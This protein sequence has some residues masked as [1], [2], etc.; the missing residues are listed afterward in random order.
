M[1][2]LKTASNKEVHWTLPWNVESE[3]NTRLEQLLGPLSASFATNVVSHG[4]YGWETPD[5]DWKPLTD[6]SSVEEA[7]ARQAFSDLSRRVKGHVAAVF[8]AKAAQYDALVEKILSVPNDGYVFYRVSGGKVEILLTGWGFK[9]YLKPKVAPHATAPSSDMLVRI[10]FT[11]D[12]EL[13]PDCPFAII[14]NTINEVKTGSDGFFVLG[15]LRPGTSL[16]VVNRLNDEEFSLNVQEDK[17]DYVFG[18]TF[19]KPAPDPAPV[20]DPLPEPDPEPDPEPEPEP[21]PDP[22]PDPTPEP[23]PASAPDPEPDMESGQDEDPEPLSDSEPGD[24][25]I[26]LVDK[27]EDAVIGA[28]MTLKGRNGKVFTATTDSRGQIRVPREFF[29]DGKKVKVTI[30]KP[31]HDIRGCKFRY[32]A[33]QDY[34]IIR[35]TDR[36]R[37]RWPW[38]LLL[39]LLPFLLLIKCEH[40]LT[41]TC[42]DEKTKAPVQGVEVTMDYTAHFLLDSAKFFVSTPYSFRDTTDADGKVVFENLRCSVWSYLFYC[43]SK[44]YV[45]ADEVN[46]VERNFHFTRH[47]LMQLENIVCE[48]DIVMCIDNTGS[49]SEFLQMVKS[50]A[51]NFGDDLKKYCA[52][53]RRD[54]AS[55]RVKVVVF[56]DLREC[57]ISQSPMF[58]L[59]EQSEE[60]KKF[61]DNIVCAGGGDDP[62]NGL[63]ALALAMN[64]D[65]RR[66]AHRHRHIIVMYTDASAHPL[67]DP[68]THTVYYPDDMPS[69]FRELTRRWRRMEKGVKRLVLYAPALYPWTEISSSWPEAT[70]C[71]DN[72]ESVF[73]G[74]SYERILEEICRSL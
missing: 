47:I 16:R 53:K 66:S 52:K 2:I 18:L 57:A 12:G 45:T 44:V 27:N 58:S 64:T 50:N 5:S 62:E 63:E 19:P 22:V 65:W 17:T 7:M 34:Y 1:P 11:K 25:T 37:R 28:E 4:V 10:G 9:N 61:I 67:E 41:V 54:I 21:V 3:A 31:G 36:K 56:G 32:Q 43:R 24:V 72:L 26:E 29:I 40:D 6:A 8:P 14:R 23:E 42:I 33:D 48:A 38:W 69:D 51:L 71:D 39:L 46:S 15:K 73:S 74:D 35:L 49:M 60:Y 30:H 70:L 20:P 13:Q 59:P 55:I 68:A